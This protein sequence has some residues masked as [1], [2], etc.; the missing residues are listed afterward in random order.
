M[1]NNFST[2]IKWACASCDMAYDY[3]IR[4][5]EECGSTSIDEISTDYSTGNR[6]INRVGDEDEEEE[7][8]DYDD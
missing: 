4:T 8:H 7:N 3:P 2:E 1:W 5:C 6:S